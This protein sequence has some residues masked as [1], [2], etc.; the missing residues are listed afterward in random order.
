MIKKEKGE[1][2]RV[3]LMIKYSK[4]KKTLQEPFEAKHGSP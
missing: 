2:S 3:K 4:K 1:T